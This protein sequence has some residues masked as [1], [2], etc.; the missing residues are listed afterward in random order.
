MRRGLVL[1]LLL[2]SLAFTARAD[3]TSGPPEQ[4]A[5][6]ELRVNGVEHGESFVVLREGDVLVPLADLRKAGLTRFEAS[7]EMLHGTP[8][9]S[10]RGASG[11]LNF[12]YDEQALSLAIIAKPALLEKTVVDLSPVARADARYD[13]DPSWFFNYAPRLIDGSA[14]QAFGE[15]GLAL[16]STVVQSSASYDDEQGATRLQSSISFDDRDNL[17]TAT[18]GDTFIS[19]GPLSG[20][21]MLGG[22]SISR[23]YA[24]DPY[25]VKIPRLGY[26]GETM[27]PATVDV[28]VNDV[29]VR[30]VPVAPGRFELTNVT[31]VAGAGTTRYVL[32]DAFGQQQRL[33]STYYA[34]SAVLAAG[35][36]EYDYGI[37]LARDSFGTESWSYGEPTFVARHRFG[38]S[39][40][41]TWGYR[42]EFDRTRAN[43]GSG[44]TLAG[45]F[46]ELEFEHA[47][48]T[49][50]DR[51]PSRGGAALLA[52]GYRWPRGAVRT[53]SRGTSPEYSTL[54]LDP[55]DDRALAEQ[56]VS[57]GFMT[58][59]STSVATNLALAWL[60]DSG[61]GAQAGVTFSARLSHAL[62]LQ[63]R[64]TRGRSWL[65]DWQND[66]FAT[67]TWS[68]PHN[69]A[70]QLIG[71]T[72]SEQSDAT[73]R[74]TRSLQGP[75]GVG[76]ELSGSLGDT[77]RVAGV[78]RGQAP[79]GQAAAT[80]TNTDGDQHSILELA[81][82]VVAVAGDVHFTVP[83]RQSFA[84]LEVPDVEGARGY[85]DNRE[86]G[87]TDADG[88]LFVPGLRAY[89]ANRLKINHADLPLEHGL[90]QEEIVL[91]PPTRGGAVVRFASR[92]MHILRGRLVQFDDKKK[93]DAP[94]NYGTLRVVVEQEVYVSPLGANG[95]FEFDGLPE[96]TWQ[97]LARSATGVCLA[98][99]TVSNPEAF[100][101]ELGTLQCLPPTSEPAAP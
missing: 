73:A 16:G 23:N 43:A 47:S 88:R 89:E 99:L 31:P 40:H 85:L 3:P 45:S 7:T 18:I 13:Y 60:R 35:L 32:R 53:I 91:S 12:E 76:Y 30:R 19:T 72:G 29:L 63:V 57:A 83:A 74:V 33:E 70:A 62:S 51:Q 2:L 84:V 48:S 82:G 1:V 55:E 52:Y 81:G 98:T 10:L 49:T 71:H 17:R 68:L 86:V 5:V 21:I 87:R 44:L 92:A 95:E 58:S 28:Y 59:N 64:G 26:T 39:R 8:H 14:L 41:L 77:R 37:G 94:V 27:A 36:S 11:S 100:M 54:T 56:V 24:L 101:Q 50:T 61:P 66:V 15:T 6:L 20:G 67:L 90:E 9:V 42:A 22:F 25:L 4:R 65:T 69:H 96:G 34:S 93:E 79:F 38:L 78:V 97:G 80:Y 46:G 75:T